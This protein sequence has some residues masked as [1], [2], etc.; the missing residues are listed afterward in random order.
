MGVCGLVNASAIQPQVLV[1]KTD[2]GTP[3]GD[4]D[5]PSTLDCFVYYY[6]YESTLVGE[7]S[8]S[9]GQYDRA[10]IGVILIR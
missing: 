2:E 4:C 10:I 8:V 7:Y 6:W 9:T 3:S 1:V 5:C